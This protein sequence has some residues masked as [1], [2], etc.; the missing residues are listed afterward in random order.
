MNSPSES[1]WAEI[2]LGAVGH[3]VRELKQITSP[4]AAFMA[5]VKADAY[6]HG[7]V[8]V[9]KAA[10]AGGADRL[11][12]ARIDEAV[13]LRQA[14]LNAPILI[15]G[16]TPPKRA[17]ELIRWNLTQTVY[18]PDTA[19]TLSNCAEAAGKPIS[20]HLK[21]DTGMGRLGMLFISPDRD[22]TD[23]VETIEKIRRL[24]GL[25]V[26]GIFT[27]FAAA[28]SIDKTYSR[29]QFERFTNLLDRLRRRRIDFPVRHCANSAGIIDLPETHLDM[30]R[31]GI[32]MYGLS[33]SDEVNVRKISLKP[34]M[35]LK[36]RIIHLKQVP[37][38]FRVSYGMTHETSAPTTIAT[39]SI[40]YADGLNRLLSSRGC[41][42]VRG[43]R[44][45]GRAH[46]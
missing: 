2:D 40:G 31:G 46:V 32:A 19:E 14:G 16:D 44:E 3:N 41:M 7:A 30:V 9:A 18:R 10:L 21:I 12:V 4:G 11:G 1:A 5:V 26:E 29:L 24:P 37:A 42:L 17:S 6:G 34:A 35:S 8:E 20:I 38:G 33:P 27:H 43:R 22:G 45:I 13:Q 15:F 23:T 28:D 36:S 39:V 25:N